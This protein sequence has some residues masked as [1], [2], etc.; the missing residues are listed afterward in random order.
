LFLFLFRDELL[1]KIDLL[2]HNLYFSLWVLPLFFLTYMVNI[3]WLQLM[4]RDGENIEDDHL[5]C[6]L[7]CLVISKHFPSSSSSQSDPLEGLGD[8]LYRVVL[9]VGEKKKDVVLVRTG[10]LVVMNLQGW[11]VIFLLPHLGSFQ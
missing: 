8:A 1:E 6:F 10:C 11:V 5:L 3:L 9:V 2:H 4:A 7:F